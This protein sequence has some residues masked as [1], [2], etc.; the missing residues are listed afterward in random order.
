ML[1][2]ARVTIECKQT[3]GTEGE[4]GD[5][6]DAAGIGDSVVLEEAEDRVCTGVEGGN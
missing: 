3:R 2:F 5:A 6:E 1:F 4:G